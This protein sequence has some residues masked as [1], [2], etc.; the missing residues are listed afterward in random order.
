[1][2]VRAC[3]PHDLFSLMCGR[4]LH[5]A[6]TK[7]RSQEVIHKQKRTKR[8][9]R[10]YTHLQNSRT[11]S[12]QVSNIQQ[13]LHSVCR[14]KCVHTNVSMTRSPATP[15]I[16][17]PDDYPTMFEVLLAWN[18]RDARVRYSHVRTSLPTFGRLR[19][20][21][22]YPHPRGRAP[23]FGYQLTVYGHDAIFRRMWPSGVICFGSLCHILVGAEIRVASIDIRT[24]RPRSHVQRH[25]LLFVGYQT[26][27]TCVRCFTW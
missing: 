10:V 23:A 14:E 1:M 3:M 13:E 27:Y 11:T 2:P 21:A 19:R 15:I 24:F 4:F 26:P 18:V 8:G 7:A 5:F 9:D 22:H 20:N 16:H 25:V 17:V 12:Y 6:Q